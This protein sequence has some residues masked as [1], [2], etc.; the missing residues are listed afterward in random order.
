VDYVPA[1]RLVSAEG[2]KYNRHE[3]AG[4]FGDL[5]TLL[6]FV[7]AYISLMNFNP[8]AI[9][10][11]FGLTNIVVGGLYKTPIPVQPMKAISMAALTHASKVTPGMVWGAGLFSGIFWLVMAS[12]G[13]SKYVPKLVK[14]PIV[15]GIVL[16]LGLSFQVGGVKMMA[17]APLIAL[18]GLF[19][20]FALRKNQKIPGIFALILFGAFTV[21]LTKPQVLGGLLMIRPSLYVPALTIKPFT[22][23]E[24]I[25][26][27]VLLA[28]P[29]L[30]LTLSNGILALVTENNDLFPSRPVSV[31]QVTLSTAVINLVTPFTGGIPM[32]HGVGGMAGHVRFGARTG[33]AT[34]ILGVA[35]LGLALVFGQ[36]LPLLFQLFPQV[37]LG[38]VMFLAGV[39]LASSSIDFGKGKVDLFLITVTAGLAVWNAG[40]ALLMGVILSLWLSSK[41]EVTVLNDTSPLK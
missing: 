35:L 19:L 18:V 25:Q 3:F 5:G 33:G 24:F 29:Q 28:L 36:S 6:P 9:L 31:R 32:C 21:I 23:D 12:T 11:G 17:Q 40:A 26:G 13:V 20:V 41:K 1:E 7:L 4:A 14:R 8:S 27:A 15:K 37:V 2:N 39:E 34:I 30:P 22:L 16:G 10:F 38:V